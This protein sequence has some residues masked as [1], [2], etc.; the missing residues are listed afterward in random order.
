M[1]GIGD[2]Y[3]AYAEGRLEDD[4]EVAVAHADA[5]HGFRALSD[6]M[7]DVRATLDAAV[8]AGVVRESTADS[9][10]GCV[11]ATFYAERALV[12]ALDRDDEE[13][14]RLR[15]W[16][17]EGRVER[18][19]EDALALLRAIR[20]DL[21]RGLDPFRPTWTLQGTRYWEEA[22]RSVEL[23]AAASPGRP[24]TRTL[25][26][27]L[28]EAR[29]DAEGFGRIADR[30]LLAALARNAAAAAG[31]DVS[32]WSHQAALEEERRARASS[33]RRT[34]TP[35]STN[36]TSTATTCLTSPVAWQCCGGRATRTATQSP[37]RWHSR[38]GRT[39]R[40]PVCCPRGAQA[41][42][43]RIAPVRLRDPRRRRAR[44]VVLPRAGGT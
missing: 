11:K 30:S 23:A 37:A 33:S 43:A 20:H 5:G 31:V 40:M 7:V 29:L 26:A 13:H 14:E 42:G 35:G 36:E 39:T 17:P 4:D 8:A 41:R 2:V 44:R 18:K 38:S 25:E 22:R 28:D 6:A 34:S 32:P 27:S 16:L 12:A 10:G 15:A 21:D 19:R 24:P 9:L 1:H 3:R